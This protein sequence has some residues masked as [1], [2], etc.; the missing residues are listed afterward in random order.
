MSRRFVA[1]LLA[2][3]LLPA[4]VGA[5]DSGAAKR[6]LEAR[7]EGI[8]PRYLLVGPGGGAVTN[9]DFRG[10]FQ[11]IAFGYTF[12]P[13]ICPTTLL[14]MATI[15]KELG[16]QAG[17]LQPLFVTLDPERDGR[18]QLQTYTEFFDSRIVGLTGSPELVRRAAQNF[19]VRYAKVAL[20]G[21]DPA[22]YAVDHAAGLILLGPDGGFVRKY[23]YGKP[24]AEI[25]GELRGLLAS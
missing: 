25:V 7:G 15:L 21:G 13:D 19:K 8:V 3:L 20:P 5:T 6:L 24:V 10:R 9:E 12:C 4:A 1:A 2:A 11:L 23:P 14:E 22:N 17:R 16:D 18:Q